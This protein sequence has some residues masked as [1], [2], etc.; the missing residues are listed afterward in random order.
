MTTKA[1]SQTSVLR[2]SNIDKKF[3]QTHALKN[4][5]LEIN[6]GEVIGLIGENGAG[7]STL[8]KILTGIYQPDS[9]SIEVNGK[10]TKFRGPRDSVAAGIGV[11][12]QE[13]SLFT[14]LTV[15]ENIASGS[16]VASRFGIYRWGQIN[17][18]AA[19]TL[20]I[21][22][23]SLDPS[24]KV[25]NLS[26][27]DRQMVEIARAIRVDSTMGG[28]PLVILDEPT[29]VLERSETAIL[30]RE[31]RK[32]KAHGSVIFVSHRLDEI[33]RNC[34]RIMVM[35]NGELV[36]D[37]VTSTVT[38]DELF[39]LMVGH[40]ARAVSS[41]HRVVAADEQPVISVEN[42]SRKGKYSN[43]SLSVHAGR[44]TAIVGSTGSGREELARA[45]FGAEKFDSG[46]IAINGTKVTGWRIAKAV[47]RGVAYVPA[48][49]K[50]EGMVGGF[51]AAENITLTHPGKAAV[52][53]IVFPLA[54]NKIARTWFN[55][56]DVRPN[57]IALDLAR[58]SGGNQQ[59][60]VMA[61]WLNSP[62]L[63]VLV[64]DHPL[65]GLDPGAAQTVNEQI[66]L[67]CSNGAAVILLS[68]T[69]EEALEMG[70]D[71][72]VMRDGEISATFDMTKESPST[73]DLLERMV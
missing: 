6:H 14:N 3:G 39:K 71:V 47:K 10:S 60:V 37:R 69:L 67:A 29:S 58:F 31:I 59:K 33:M 72:I 53:P 57:D 45:L 51:S 24:T 26:F 44:L 36:A 43:V 49:R 11:V 30:E 22:G 25:S 27:V 18:A 66:K 23:S 41:S 35:R 56:L 34:D 46:S 13:Q 5:S 64:L 32:L 54:R 63:S 16:K 55:T 38:E 73:L 62:E 48:E 40:E 21:I 9:G 1:T 12:H 61:K 52:G 17:R 20:S 68:D 65:R 70:D 7:K 4:V 2:L 19:E 15:A 8:L 28:S 50:V 42:L